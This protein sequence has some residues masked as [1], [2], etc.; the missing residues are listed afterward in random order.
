MITQN[1]TYSYQLP[2]SKIYLFLVGFPSEIK[3][4]CLI[5]DLCRLEEEDMEMKISELD[6]VASMCQKI[7]LSR[8]EI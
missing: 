5:L 8:G 6:P 3:F 4:D 2:D 7:Y 1:G